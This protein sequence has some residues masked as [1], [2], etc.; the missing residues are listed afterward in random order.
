M[1]F[2]PNYRHFEDV[3]KNVRPARLPL[4]E[5][6]VSDGIMEEI[7]DVKFAHLTGGDE[8]D[9]NEY[10]RIYCDFFKIMTYDTVSFEMCITE[11]LPG[12]GAINGGMK[13]PIQNRDDF[14]KYPWDEIP[15]FILELRRKIS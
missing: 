4:Y 10:F 2:Q 13:G 9:L 7:L 8:N 11:I 14:E 15:V 3:M 5:H 6:I 1:N 12:H